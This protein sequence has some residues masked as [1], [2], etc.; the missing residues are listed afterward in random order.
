MGS[1]QLLRWPLRFLAS[2]PRCFCLAIIALA[3]CSVFVRPA[4]S[5]E[6]Q[7]TSVAEAARRARE[8]KQKKESAKPEKVWTNDNLNAAQKTQQPA[9]PSGA[10]SNQAANPG[11]SSQEPATTPAGSSSP[12]PAKKS[13]D[14]TKLKAELSET[15]QQLAD[16]EKDLDL[17]QRDWD[18]RRDQYYS[19]PDFRLDTSGKAT[20]DAIQ[21][22][23]TEQ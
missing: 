8:E 7:D 15:K 17:S 11:T 4:L 1:R 14:N 18:L 5:Q 9:Q 13:E 23:I 10:A 22:Q 3:V 19:N 16:A 12:T 21:Q 6:G 2:R 20:L